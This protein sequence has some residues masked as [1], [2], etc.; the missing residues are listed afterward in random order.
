[1]KIVLPLFAIFL[2]LSTQAAT[3]GTLNLIGIVPKK[4]EITVTPKPI[5]STLDLTTTASDLSVG[6]VT[7]KSNVNAGYKLTIIS[8]NAGKLVNS[9]ASPVLLTQ[10]SYTMK[11]DA[12]S[13]N[14]T[15]STE[16]NFTGKTPFTKDV[17]ISYTGIDAVLYEEGN[18]TDTVTFTISAN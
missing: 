12:A 1:M 2:S 11:L 16:L 13:V 5:A 7:G 15:S 8:A 6:T 14:L 3:V 4:V 9:V 18:F 10:V 17:T